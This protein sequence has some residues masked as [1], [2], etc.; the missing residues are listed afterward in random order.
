MTTT[1]NI[2]LRGFT[3]DDLKPMVQ[4]ANHCA[5]HDE[6]E[7]QLTE[8]RLQ[9]MVSAPHID[10]NRDLLLAVTPAGEIVGFGSG[11][12]IP[13]T[14]RAYN[15]G[16]VHPGYRGQGLGTRLLR[17][18][19]ALIL[20]RV[21]E[22]HLPAG[23]PVHLNTGTRDTREDV[24]AL[25]EAGGYSVTRYFFD[26]RRTLD[27]PLAPVPLPDGLEFRPFDI[28]Q[29]GRAVYEAQQEAFRDHWGHVDM[30]FEAWAHRRLN[31]DDQD[32]DLWMVAW[33]GDEIAGMTLNSQ[34]NPQHP[35]HAEVEILGVR[36]AWRRR[37]LGY[38]LLLNT[39]HLFQQRGWN[40]AGLGVDAASKTNAVALY[41]R[42]GMHVHRRFA[43]YRKIL[44]GKAE[45]IED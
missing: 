31:V 4:F 8:E 30:P 36:R 38:A 25:F 44:R 43:T 42:A 15:S 26:M 33:D 16:A 17:E 9:L 27:T 28:E 37:G 39:F 29:H 14:G 32:H 2:T 19:E 40:E 22:E 1:P 13:D 21:D 12:L 11:V 35:D 7:A 23:E 18:V 41:E 5:A 3:P 45:D 10:A 20:R 6:D 24:I 34:P